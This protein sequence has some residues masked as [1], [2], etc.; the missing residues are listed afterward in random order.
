[1]LKLSTRA[2]LIIDAIKYAGKAS[3]ASGLIVA[4]WDFE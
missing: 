1:M 2:K 4:D 3:V